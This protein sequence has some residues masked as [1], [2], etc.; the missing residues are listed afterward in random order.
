MSGLVWP[1]IPPFSAHR[2]L[3]GQAV[4]RQTNSEKPFANFSRWVSPLS[5]VLY[6]YK[7]AASPC[8]RR[9][10]NVRGW[11][12]GC[13]LLEN[14]PILL[15]LEL[16]ISVFLKLRA[17]FKPWPASDIAGKTLSSLFFPSDPKAQ[18]GC[19]G[20]LRHNAAT[21]MQWQCTVHGKTP[22]DLPSPQLPSSWAQ[23]VP[24]AVYLR[25]NRYRC[26]WTGGS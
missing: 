21:L 8:Y 12:L 22:R 13:D 9:N 25:A 1:H 26:C 11:S 2:N 17:S 5:S 7:D 19:H 20:F 4:S 16:N 23:A 3:I 18:S 6:K 10:R 24:S 14:K 15:R